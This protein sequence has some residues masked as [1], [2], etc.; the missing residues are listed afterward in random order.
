MKQLTLK[1]GLQLFT[2]DEENLP[3][4]TIFPGD[5][6][7]G[8]V[9]A[10][11]INGVFLIEHGE[12]KIKHPEWGTESYET[13]EVESYQMI[14]VSDGMIIESREVDENVF[15]TGMLDEPDD[16]LEGMLVDYGF[17]INNGWPFVSF[18]VCGVCVACV[19]GVVASGITLVNHRRGLVR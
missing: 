5:V 18:A 19:G 11:W 15:R 8:L 13:F 7:D 16:V 6:V 1:S 2:D 4:E 9:K 14:R 3:L 10:D 17:S 12:V